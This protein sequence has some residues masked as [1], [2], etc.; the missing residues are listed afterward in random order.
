MSR[1]R[2]WWAPGACTALLVAG[3]LAGCAGDDAQQ[4]QG[5]QATTAQEEPVPVKIG[6][7]GIAADAP[8]WLGMEK[9]Y[10]EEEGIEVTTEVS[11][12]G[13]SAFVPALLGGDLDVGAGGADGAIQA[14]AK[15][16]DV[17]ILAQDGAPVSHGH[18]A[19]STEDTDHIT[20]AVMS[21]EG[22]DVRTLKDLEGETVAAITVSGLQY[23]CVQRAMELAGA[24]P[25]KVK[26]LE[27]PL[28][29]M[30]PAMETDRV[31][32]AVLLEPFV[33]QAKAAG[34][35]VVSYACEEALPGV[36]QGAYFVSGE[37][38]RQN[39]QVAEGLA[40][41]LVRA[42]RYA[43]ENP[44]EVRRVIAENTKIPPEAAERMALYPFPAPEERPQP[45]TLGAIADLMVRYGHIEEKPDIQKGLT[46]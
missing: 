24:D 11:G 4:G 16:L 29:D 45:N 42:N 6:V 40:N 30:I 43:Q 38:A 41:G 3:A 37:W 5:A 32:A 17:K 36:I 14:M 7:L 23:L 15:G 10:F 9:G 34:A 1:M 27:T 18:T 25:K 35:N 46:D 13:G 21:K 31:G 39:P 20:L 33:T 2:T 26:V 44:E 8:I 19:A 28:P 22:S 12:A